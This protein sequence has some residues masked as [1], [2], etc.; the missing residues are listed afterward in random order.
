M[1]RHSYLAGY[2]AP[3]LQVPSPSTREAPLCHPIYARHPTLTTH[4][5]TLLVLGFVV[6][7][8]SIA[9]RFSSF[10]IIFAGE[11]IYTRYYSMSS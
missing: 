2:Q 4:T 10:S 7:K 11:D 6:L 8:L 1:R 3:P 9:L 5:H